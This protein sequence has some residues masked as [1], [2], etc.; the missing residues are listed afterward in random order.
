MIEALEKGEPVEKTK[1]KPD[2][3]QIIN[4]NLE[5]IFNHYCNI[6]YSVA[7]GLKTFEKYK[8]S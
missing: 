6:K 3:E 8:T 1:P 4:K 5:F 2:L 7:F